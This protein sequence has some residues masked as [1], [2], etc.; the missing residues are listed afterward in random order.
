VNR[1]ALLI[2]GESASFWTNSSVLT[3]LSKS[4]KSRWSIRNYNLK[5]RYPRLSYP[6]SSRNGVVYSV[7][8]NVRIGI[9]WRTV[10]LWVSREWT[11]LNQNNRWCACSSAVI[12]YVK[13][14]W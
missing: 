6:F 4:W 5:L 14:H 1:A 7:V 13:Q 8:I 3:L 11:K 2:P 12:L 9:D 10:S